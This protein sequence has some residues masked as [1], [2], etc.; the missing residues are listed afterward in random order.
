MTQRH[1]SKLWEPPPRASLQLVRF[2]R[3]FGHQAAV[4]AGMTHASGDA[5]IFLDADLQ[6]PPDLIPVFLERFKEG[7]DVVYGVRLN[8]KESLWLRLCFKAYYRIFNRIAQRP[9]PLDAGDFGLM[10]SR[11]AKLVAAMPE[12]D[13][14]VRGLRSWVGFKQIGVPYDRPERLAGESRYRRGPRIEGALDGLFGFSKVPIRFAL[15]LGMVVI[16][17]GII[18]L[19]KV[20]IT[21]LFFDTAVPGW[22]S[23][24]T[25]G[26]MVAGA[27][28]VATAI[29]GEYVSRIYFQ[30]KSRP[31]FVVDKVI[32]KGSNSSAGASLYI[33]V[34]RPSQ[35]PCINKARK[36]S[37]IHRVKSRKD[38]GD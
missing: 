35:V 14:L 29:V 10:S 22:K 3:N 32:R 19:A 9:I 23:L 25:L 11:V 33:L 21:S 30:T 2:S 31:L 16:V 18:Y 4:S 38:D 37:R 7:Y 27:N 26:F 5:L 1:S 15:G 8:R 34:K 13:R 24:A 17:V 20:Y 6:D 28:I 12:H 36:G